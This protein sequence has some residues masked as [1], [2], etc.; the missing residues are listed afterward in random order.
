MIFPF[1]YCFLPFFRIGNIADDGW[2]DGGG[3]DLLFRDPA[4]GLR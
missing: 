3:G 1:A 2:M 4:R